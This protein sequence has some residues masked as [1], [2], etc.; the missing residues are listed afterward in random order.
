MKLIIFISYASDELEM[1]EFVKSVLERVSNNH[2]KGFVAKRDISSGADPLKTM[3]DENLKNA[4][5]IIP[6]CSQKSKESSWVWWESASTWARDKKVYPLFTNITATG[7]GSPLNL[8]T[9]GKEFFVREEFLETIKTAC[10][11]LGI[12]KENIGLTE[13]ENKIYSQ[14]QDKYSKEVLAAQVNIGYRTLEQNQDYHKYSL[15][16]DIKNEANQAIDD[17]VLDLYFP[18]QYLIIKKWEYGHLKSS[19]SRSRPGYLCLTFVFNNMPE[20]GIKQFSS[21]L[22]PGKT[23]KVYGPEGITRLEYDIDDSRSAEAHKFRMDYE[24]FINRG[25]PQGDSIEFR[26]LLNF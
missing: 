23:L 21:Y 13:E 18:E 26:Q 16:F 11:E 22:L 4:D 3:L 24:L 2:I 19:Q 25:A 12:K 17:L 7:F 6:I 20:S 14:L 9:Q 5:A 8:V 1:A 10:E 15:L